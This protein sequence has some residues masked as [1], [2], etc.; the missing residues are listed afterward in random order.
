MVPGGGGEH[1]T[2]Q[3]NKLHLKNKISNLP[4]GPLFIPVEGGMSSLPLLEFNTNI[5]AAAEIKRVA[6]VGGFISAFV[7]F[8]EYE[9][10]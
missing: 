10:Q 9:C 2:V 4:E 3:E 8:I 1:C 7:R 5:R 6:V